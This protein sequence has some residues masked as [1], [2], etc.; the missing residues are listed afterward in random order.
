MRSLLHFPHNHLLLLS[1]STSWR[2]LLLARS[3]SFAFYTYRIFFYDC[4][5]RTDP[6]RPSLKML[7]KQLLLTPSYPSSNAAVLSP[8]KRFRKSLTTVLHIA[9]LVFTFLSMSLFAAAIPRWNANFFHNTGPSRGDWTDG[10]PL[11]PLVFALLYH[12]GTLIHSRSIQKIRPSNTNNTLPNNTL[13]SRRT[14]LIDAAVSSLI[15]V[16]LFPSLFLAGYGS[17]FR[18]WRPAMRTQSGGVPCTMLNVFSRECQP[19]LYSVGNL[20]LAGIV[21]GCTVWMCHFALL[22]VTLRN[23][24]RHSLI[25][26]VQSEKWTQFTNSSSS[27]D[28]GSTRSA[29]RSARSRTLSIKAYYTHGNRRGPGSRTASRDGS[30]ERRSGSRLA[31]GSGDEVQ[32]P[33]ESRP[34]VLQRNA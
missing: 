30:A 22:L 26:K 33:I 28:G 15:L 21:F 29:S 3:Y 16:T 31:T 11:G 2:R 8:A 12:T 25:K 4:R 10:M 14:L 5:P 20:Q 6:T 23:V 7:T 1:T 13:T 32:I 18:F 17:L 24:R 19:V 9:S 27:S 34:P